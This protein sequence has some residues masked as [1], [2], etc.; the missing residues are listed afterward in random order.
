MRCHKEAEEE[1][2]REPEAGARLAVEDRAAEADR[3]VEQA[4]AVEVDRAV[5]AVRAGDPAGAV[6]QIRGGATAA[7]RDRIPA[8]SRRPVAVSARSA[9]G[10]RLTC[11]GFPASRTNAR[12]VM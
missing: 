10:P 12:T 9:A 8:H 5:E 2:E 3:A 6:E 4:R 7:P 1:A 11:G